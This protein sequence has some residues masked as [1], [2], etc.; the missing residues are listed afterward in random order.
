MQSPLPMSLELQPITHRQYSIYWHSTG[1]ENEWS[2]A[3][4]SLDCSHIWHRYDTVPHLPDISHTVLVVESMRRRWRR[5]IFRQ[6]LRDGSD[7]RNSVPARGRQ[8]PE[9]WSHGAG[10]GNRGVSLLARP[11]KYACPGCN[12]PCRHFDPLRPSGA[13]ADFGR[14]LHRRATAIAL[15]PRVLHVQLASTI[16][17]PSHVERWRLSCK[18]SDDLRVFIF[19]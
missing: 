6:S 14:R 9:R 18:D 2:C 1:L 8:N 7:V 11:P 15:C 12:R 5:S 4:Q 10:R 19:S 3:N 13:G 16:Q 17:L